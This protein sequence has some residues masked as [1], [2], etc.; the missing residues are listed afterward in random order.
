MR[1]PEIN[2][3]EWKFSVNLTESRAI[4]RQ[5][6]MPAYG[7]TCSACTAWKQYYRSNLPEDI[8][9]SFERIGIDL[10]HPSEC[11]GHETESGVHTLRVIFHF[12]GVMRSGP[13]PQVYDSTIRETIM[14]YV[15]I[16]Q[17]PRLSI[18]VLPS[19]KSF[20][21]SPVQKNG[22]QDGILCIDMRLDLVATDHMNP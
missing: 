17:E 2:F 11:Y 9:L 1:R 12:V 15:T 22:N 8:L 18:M 20:E 14:N 19:K 7:C 21:P 16:R 10:D 6:G 13:A 4:Q 3:S 5:E